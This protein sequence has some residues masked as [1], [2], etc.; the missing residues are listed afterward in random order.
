MTAVLI[1]AGR[2]IISIEDV[3]RMLAEPDNTSVHPSRH[4]YSVP[5][6]GLYLASVQYDEKGMLG[7][8]ESVGTLLIFPFSFPFSSLP[9]SLLLSCF[10]F[11]L[12]ISNE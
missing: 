12:Q 7:H 4:I 3:R 10:P 11:Q 2:H 1:A 8:C 5:S 9:P 6:H